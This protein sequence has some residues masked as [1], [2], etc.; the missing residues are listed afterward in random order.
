LRTMPWVSLTTFGCRAYRQPEGLPLEGHEPGHGHGQIR[1]DP[2]GSVTFR[3]S[4]GTLSS[5]SS[6]A[7]SRSASMSRRCERPPR[8][9]APPHRRWRP[10]K[11]LLRRAGSREPPA[12][13]TLSR[14]RLRTAPERSRVHP[15]AFARL[16]MAVSERLCR[17]PIQARAIS[18]TAFPRR[19]AGLDHLAQARGGREPRG[20][21]RGR[22]AV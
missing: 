13:T 4:R 7:A 12:Q 10:R 11:A 15:F 18:Q 1:D 9:R 14:T 2:T 19:A 8:P 20:R 3:C 17:R 6:T 21:G 5:D 22:T 16:R